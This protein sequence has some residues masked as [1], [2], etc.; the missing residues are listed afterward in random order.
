MHDLH[1]QLAADLGVSEAA[2]FTHPRVMAQYRE[3][4]TIE[5]LIQTLQDEGEL[6]DQTLAHYVEAHKPALTIHQ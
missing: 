5:Q 4:L 3:L 1:Q 2:Y 6:T